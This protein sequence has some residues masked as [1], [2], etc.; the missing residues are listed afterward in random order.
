MSSKEHLTSNIWE[1][2]KLCCAQI[3]K[4]QNN[5]MNKQIQTATIIQSCTKEVLGLQTKETIILTGACKIFLCTN[6][7][8]QK[9]LSV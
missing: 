1:G 8:R 6:W 7:L 4:H 3:R 9:K 2:G 5:G